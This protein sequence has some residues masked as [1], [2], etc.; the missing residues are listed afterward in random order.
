[1][2]KK[3]N[4]KVKKVLEISSFD[5]RLIIKKYLL[6][7]GYLVSGVKYS[8]STVTIYLK[9]S[10]GDVEIVY[11]GEEFRKIIE[12][13]PVQIKM[14]IED[15]LKKNNIRVLNMRFEEDGLIVYV[16]DVGKIFFKDLINNYNEQFEDIWMDVRIVNI[17]KSMSPSIK[18]IFD[19][20]QYLKD[21]KRKKLDHT[22]EVILKTIPK[23]GNKG[24]S[25]IIDF[26]KLKN[27]KIEDTGAIVPMS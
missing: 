19:L 16:E 15:D 13:N 21:Q 1:M 24:Y 12:L 27:L 20:D 8:K 11:R 6:D 5:V 3:I 4:I 2:K 25:L 14:I 7:E 17:L 9:E 22:P 18:S 26:L 10:I 23:L